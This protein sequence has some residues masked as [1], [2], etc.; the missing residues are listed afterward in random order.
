MAR[1]YLLGSAIDPNPQNIKT[2]EIA[3]R[4]MWEKLI[5]AG[6]PRYEAIMTV[7][8]IVVDYLTTHRPASA[9]VIKTL[10][11]FEALNLLTKMEEDNP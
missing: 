8:G 7:A 6:A 4:W 2:R 9:Q 10:G 1:D 11:G 3:E 5:D